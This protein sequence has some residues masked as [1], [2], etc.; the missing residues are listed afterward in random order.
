MCK[1]AMFECVGVSVVDIQSALSRALINGKISQVFPPCG[2]F[3][4]ALLW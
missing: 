2:V 4:F 3:F 1:G